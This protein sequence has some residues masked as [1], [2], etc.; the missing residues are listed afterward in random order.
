MVGGTDFGKTYNCPDV[1]IDDPDALV[2]N[3]DDAGEDVAGLR[4]EHD[5]GQPLVNQ[6]DYST[7]QLPF[8]AFAESVTTRNTPRRTC[9][10]S[11]DGRR[12]Q[13]AETTP[14]FVWFAAN[15]DFNG[16]GP[17]DGL[18]GILHFLGADQSG[19]PVQRPGAGPV[20]VRD[21]AGR[22]EFGRL[23]MDPTLKSALIVT[24]DEDNNNITLGIETRA[25]TSSPW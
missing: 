5:P 7:D 8:P 1:C 11:T 23:G 12:F 18:S 4:P 20:L 3:I 19:S 14:N 16:E 9:S 24:F 21:R 13:S 6:G 25:T 22:D 15:E 17:V 2:F 10:C